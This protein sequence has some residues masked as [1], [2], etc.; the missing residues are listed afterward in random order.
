[1]ATD[2]G[3]AALGVMLTPNIGITIGTILDHIASHTANISNTGYVVSAYFMSDL[4]NNWRMSQYI[5]L[6]IGAPILIASL[7]M[8]E[9]FKHQIL[10]DRLKQRGTAITPHPHPFAE[11]RRRIRTTIVRPL[12]MMVTEP[13]V[14]Y[15]SIYTGFVFG[16]IFSFLASYSYVFPKIY[17][18]GTKSTGLTF[19]AMLPGYV[20]GLVIFGIFDKTLYKRARE[21]ANGKPAP[22]HRLYASM[23]G[24]ILL[25]ISLFWFAWSPKESVHW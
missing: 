23:I 4:D 3:P 5:I 10:I 24:S 12:H 15:L 19:L 14:A 17:N 13:L 6:I 7:F 9:T 2:G 16:M 21:R 18:F 1:M 11:M 25:P 22:E 20:C 8:S